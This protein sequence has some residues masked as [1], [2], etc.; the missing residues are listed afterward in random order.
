MR[1]PA[2]PP[3]VFPDRAEPWRAH[4]KLCVHCATSRLTTPLPCNCNVSEPSNLSVAASSSA[5]AHRLSQQLLNGGRIVLV[6]LAGFR[7]AADM[8]TA[9]PRMGC[10]SRD[11]ATDEIWAR[12]PCRPSRQPANFFFRSSSSCADFTLPPVAFMTWPTKKPN[13]LS[14]PERK[15]ASWPGFFAMHSSMAFSMAPVSAGSASDP[16]T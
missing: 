14:L 7:H 10:R 1:E 6:L 8:R 9:W 4:S 12:S 11:E 5:R 2:S 13:S 16:S 15:S 3:I